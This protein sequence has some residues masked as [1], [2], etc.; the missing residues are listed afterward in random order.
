M[1]DRCG[2]CRYWH[3]RRSETEIR[4]GE[5]RRFP[6]VL[7]ASDIRQHAGALGWTLPRVLEHH[8]CG[9]WSSLEVAEALAEG[10]G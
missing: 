4:H 7:W 3:E 9:E 6:P 1:D 2:T 8:W 10:D 5:C